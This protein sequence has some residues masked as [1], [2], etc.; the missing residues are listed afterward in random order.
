MLKVAGG[1]FG[2][3]VVLFG[4]AVL[5]ARHAVDRDHAAVTRQAQFKQIGLDLNAASDFL[6]EQARKYAVT[7]DRA[8]LDAYWREIEVTKSRDRAVA[9]LKR[10][11]AESD[12]LELVQQA[13]QNS[14]SLVATESRAERLM[15]EASGVAVAD[16]PAAIGAFELNAAD[17]ALSPGGKRAVAR[18]IMF[19]NKYSADKAHIAAPM[20]QFQKLLNGR[21]ERASADA[22]SSVSHWMAVL[23]GLVILFPLGLA[24][25]GWLFVRQIVAP[26]NAYCKALRSRDGAALGFAL[27]PA[28]VSELHVLADEFNQQFKANEKI[29]ERLMA[30]L[31]G[32]VG[33][34]R[35]T[36]SDVLAASQQ[37]AATSGEAG[38][39]VEEIA[40]AVGEVAEGAERQVHAVE[41]ARTATEEMREASAQSAG[42]A[43]ETAAAAR[44]AIEIAQE[45]STAI[46]EATAAMGSVHEASAE[47]T[48]T[49]R[50]LGAKSDEIGGIVDAITG[51]A[52]QTN[53]LAL[54]AAIEAARAGEQGRG[55]AVVA[56]EVRKLAEESQ[57]AAA[58]IAVLIK[59]IQTETA[60]AV[61][62]VNHGAQRTA[63]GAATVEQARE[64]FTRIGEAVDEMHERVSEIAGAIGQLADTSAGIEQSMGEV[65]AVAEETSASSEQVSA[66]TQQTSASTQEIAT[67]AETL[68]RTAARLSELVDGIQVTA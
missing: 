29:T 43:R 63:A 32:V 68:A 65:A 34:V 2:V 27:H 15:L 9:A 24:A 62:V 1:V 60:H 66:S 4:A 21:A 50:S 37:M 47:T 49:I 58:S 35:T 20:T 46:G 19:D 42:S 12:E 14:D 45:G 39:A 5:M 53:L 55:F 7:G 54:N 51:I 3:M 25:V 36:A 44:R 41:R 22:R 64:Y 28:G 59:E 67:S 16:M 13:K 26:I 10:L 6:T 33:D 11:H 48:D 17:E 38:R 57:S 31:S 61:E 56:E 30:D 18:R 40:N 8:Y 52:E 23:L